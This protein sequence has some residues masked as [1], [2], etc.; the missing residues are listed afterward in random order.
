MSRS[1]EAILA[2]LD[3]FTRGYLEC[4]LWSS[5]DESRPDGGDPM[6]QRYSF[7]DISIATLLASIADCRA[8]CDAHDV[9]LNNALG[10]G[11]T[12]SS[13]GHDFW[14]TRNRHG[15]GFWDRGLGEIGTRL[16]DAA[17]VYGSVDLYV[18]RGRIHGA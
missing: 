5:N 9:D 14:L 17:H 8:F 18:Y 10:N 3:E 16:T 1:K 6:D 13:A 15:A 11:Y 2:S 4:A 7:R 12:S